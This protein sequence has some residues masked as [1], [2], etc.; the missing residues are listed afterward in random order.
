[1]PTLTRRCCSP[2]CCSTRRWAGDQFLLDEEGSAR[3]YPIAK[4]RREAI[5]RLQ[6]LAGELGLSPASRSKVSSIKG[7]EEKPAEKLRRQATERLKLRRRDGGDE[8]RERVH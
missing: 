8:E 1:L 6:S 3:K 2:S 5:A 7:N 4:E